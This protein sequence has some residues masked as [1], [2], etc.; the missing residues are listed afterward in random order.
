MGE[1]SSECIRLSD[2][3]GRLSAVINDVAQWQQVE[4]SAQALAN[5]L[6]VKDGPGAFSVFDRDISLSLIVPYNAH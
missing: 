6:R 2:E 4:I 3:L 1:P 5:A